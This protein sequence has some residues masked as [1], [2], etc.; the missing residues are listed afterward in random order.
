M[1]SN[2]QKTPIAKS[3]E[4]FAERK[5]AD[6][7][8]KLGKALP[9]QV[10]EVNG[11]IVTVSF[12]VQADPFTLPQIKMPIAGPEWARAPT[13][14]GDKGVVFPADV[15]IGGITGLGVGLASLVRPANLSALTFFPIGNANWSA[16]DDPN[17]WVLYGP[18]GVILRDS[19]GNC[20]FVLDQNNITV[21]G[22]QQLKLV[23]GSASITVTNGAIDIEG[24]L[25][26][27]GQPY[28]NHTHSAVQTGSDNSGPV[29][30]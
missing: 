3:L 28:L 29:V 15:A 30:P 7:I 25:T 11:S 9:A 2:A 17:A 16:T 14:K 6:A 5:V 24:T 10:E 12:Q 8:Q 20:K 21:T 13:Q 26:I 22:K 27:N 19:G 1:A 4:Q 18:N 23:V